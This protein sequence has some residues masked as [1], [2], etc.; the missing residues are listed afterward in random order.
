MLISERAELLVERDFH[1]RHL[2]PVPLLMEANCLL[3][4]ASHL[5]YC[6]ANPANCLL[7]VPSHLAHRHM[8]GV[9]L[10]SR[11][12]NLHIAQNIKLILSLKE[13]P[14]FAVVLDNW[15]NILQSSK[16]GAARQISCNSSCF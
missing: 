4:L 5:A 13:T 11:K 8:N 12:A 14:A 10:L 15:E 2:L 7:A 1:L 16:P 9:D 6:R 3:V